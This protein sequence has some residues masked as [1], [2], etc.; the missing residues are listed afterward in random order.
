MAPQLPPISTGRA[1]SLYSPYSPYSN[2]HLPSSSDSS[3]NGD[4]GTLPFPAALLRNDFL[5]PDFEPTAY[6]SSLFPSEEGTTSEQRH[7]TL[8]DLRTELRE[9]SSAISA[10]LLELVNANY[11]SFLSLGDELRGGDERVEDVRVALFGFRRSME[12]VQGRVKERR[13]AVSDASRDL[14]EIQATISA[15][16]KLLEID[17]RITLLEER[18]AIAADTG[19]TTDEKLAGMDVG[20]WDTDETD[21]EHIDEDALSGRAKFYVGNSPSKLAMLANN[22][23]LSCRA[24]KYLGPNLVFAK[25]ADERLAKCRETLLLDLNAALKEARKSSS[26]GTG[27]ARLLKILAVYRKIDGED[28]AVRVLKER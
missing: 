26:G 5:T 24:L 22:L 20:I 16:R 9:R 3:D 10:E 18:L 15:G 6:L 14:G 21:D 27:Q 28:E 7:Q 2:F 17:D 12:D 13:R 4:D 23:I 1:S 19:T 25:L 8:E 11:T